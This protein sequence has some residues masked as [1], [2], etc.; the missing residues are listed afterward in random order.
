[1]V[2]EIDLHLHPLWQRK[3]IGH[4]SQHFPNV[5]F[6]V[7]AHSPL[8]VQA[9]SGVNANIALL[10]EE[11]DH[12]VID[13]DVTSIRGWRIDQILTSDLFDLPT[14]RP[15]EFDQAIARRRELLTMAQLKPKEQLEL[16]KLDKLIGSLPIGESGAEMERLTALAEETARLLRAGR[17]H[18]SD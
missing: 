2:D 18:A 11:G 16:E 12:V 10:K 9:A 15:P 17:S 14:A 7:S 13:N 5:Q 4:L 3:L 1:L 6:I 8:I